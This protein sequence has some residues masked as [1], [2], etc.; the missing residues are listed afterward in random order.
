MSKASTTINEVYNHAVAA[1]AISAA[2][3]VGVFDALRTEGPLDAE[4]FAAE[5]GLDARSMQELFRALAAAEVVEREGSKVRPGSNFDEADRAKSLFHWTTRGCGELFA[6]LPDLIRVENREGSFYRRDAAAISVACRE[7]NAEW[8][9]PVFWPVVSELDFTHVADLGC[10]SGERLI[11]LA[12]SREGVRGLGIDA[13]DGAIEVATKSV[14]DAGL[15]DRI[16]ITQGDATALEPRPEYAGVDLLT[17]FMMGHD[18]W[19]R[20]EAVASLRRI[21]EVFPD[22][23]HFLLADATRTTAYADT[24][25]PV[26]SMAFEFAHAVMGDYLPTLEEWRPVFEEA[27]WRLVGE[28]PISVPAESVMFHLEPVR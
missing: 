28:H 23:K 17:S 9:D 19:P 16:S 14:A 1:S 26:F 7:I 5:R 2:W 11:K 12:R 6:T 27:G 21:R 8:W 20:A 10:G 24:E 18:F 25:M 15:S 4:A 22:L 3:E 13:A